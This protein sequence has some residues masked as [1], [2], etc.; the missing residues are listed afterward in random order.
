MAISTRAERVA[1]FVARHR[2]EFQPAFKLGF[3]LLGVGVF[4]EP[5]KFKI[6]GSELL[7]DDLVD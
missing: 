3:R 1:Q 5:D 6:G 2:V 4:V 7:G